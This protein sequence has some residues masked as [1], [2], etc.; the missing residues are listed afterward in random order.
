MPIY[1][2][3]PLEGLRVEI[4]IC[5]HGLFGS[6]LCFLK[7][8]HRQFFEIENSSLNFDKKLNLH[9]KIAKFCHVMQ[10]YVT[11][12]HDIKNLKNEGP[13]KHE[14]TSI[15]VGSVVLRPIVREP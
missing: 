5:R 10:Y 9:Q 14:K 4:D 12:G 13:D 1:I 7:L 6:L 11:T 2:K 15:G 3:R 8:C